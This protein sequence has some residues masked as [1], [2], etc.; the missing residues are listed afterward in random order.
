MLRPIS[1]GVGKFERVLLPVEIGKRGVS[2]FE[3]LRK[4]GVRREKRQRAQS[5]GG[6][7]RFV[8]P[9]RRTEFAQQFE[10]VQ[11]HL[12]VTFVQNFFENLPADFGRY[13]RGVG[14]RI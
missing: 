8:V 5:F 7:L 14:Q 11:Q 2:Q 9:A 1:R 10:I 3:K 6:R 12:L 13:D 4:G